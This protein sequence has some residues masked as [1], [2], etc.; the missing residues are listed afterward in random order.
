M[1][2][3]VFWLKALEGVVVTEGSALLDRLRVHKPKTCLFQLVVL[4]VPGV[5]GWAL[6]LSTKT[7]STLQELILTGF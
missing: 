5:K 4:V 2:Q 6:M 7:L 1:G 3:L